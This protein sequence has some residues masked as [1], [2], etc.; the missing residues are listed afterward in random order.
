MSLP[1]YR[2]V[3]QDVVK[4]LLGEQTLSAMET[5]L[6]VES[7]YWSDDE[8]YRY[9]NDAYVE[10][11]KFS[12]ALEVIELISTTAGTGTYT[13]PATV[14]QVFRVSYDNRK[15][16]PTTKWELD[17]TE[18]DWEAQTGYVS[19]YMLT[20]MNN[21]RIRLFKTP[22]VSGGL[23]VQGGEYGVIESISDGENTYMFSAEYGEVSDTAGTNWDADFIGEYGLATITGGVENTFTVWATKH[24]AEL[25]GTLDTPELPNWSHMG[26]AFRAAAK[27]LRKYGEQGREDIA[28]AYDQIS[29]D[30]LTLLRGHVA[31]RAPERLLA[32]GRRS[33]KQRRPKVWE[34]LVE[35]P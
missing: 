23:A 3:I 18:H 33:E 20:Q 11:A 24:P 26:I 5:V 28:D 10:A 25:E 6:Q 1:M 16:Y 27:A 19:H 13:L 15:V 4:D 2:I 14:G 34:T 31:N 7:D 32:M 17:R 8:L 9:I 30:Y 22:D 35:E 12:K 29:N 21:R